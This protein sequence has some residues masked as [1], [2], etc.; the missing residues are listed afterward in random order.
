MKKDEQKRCG[1][2]ASPIGYPLYA[3]HKK[4]CVVSLL[5]GLMGEFTKKKPGPS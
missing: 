4:D 5:V 2:T 3:E 1:P